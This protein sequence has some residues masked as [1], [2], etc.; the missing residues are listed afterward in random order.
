MKRL[1]LCAAVI[2]LSFSAAAADFYVSSVPELS[3]ALA[4]AADGDR[5]VLRPGEYAGNFVISKKIKLKGSPGAFIDAKGRGTALLIRSSDAEVSDLGIKNFGSDL[6]ERDAGVR[7]DEGFK[8]VRLHQLNITGPGFGVRAD[9]TENVTVENCEIR[10]ERKMHVLDRGDGVYFNYVKNASLSGNKVHYTRD[11]F[12]FENTDNTDSRGNSFAGLQYGIHYMFTRGDRAQDNKARAVIGG[13]ALMS[14]ERIRLENSESQGAVE[15]GV[16]L[17][18]TKDSIVRGNKAVKTHNRRGRREL[19]TEGKGLFIYGA[20]ANIVENNT[21]EGNDVGIGIALGGEENTLTRNRIINNRLQV[22]YVGSS[23]L[24]W[25]SGKIGNYWSGYQGWDLNRDGIGDVPYQ[26]N[27]SLDRLF[28]LYPQIRFLME[29]PLIV[30]LKFMTA[31]FD[32]DKDK[33]VTDAYPLI[34]DPDSVSAERVSN[35]RS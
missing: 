3:Q 15:F 20:G 9:R 6:Y 30:L 34:V 14:S 29:S 23:R 26:P 12:Y 11:G 33:G 18:E 19:D 32:F 7:I 5:I 22:R 28:W 25:S 8:N 31:K 10:G 4:A 24:E 35:E 13:Y 2:M 17:N 21:F 16:L 27:D 1:V